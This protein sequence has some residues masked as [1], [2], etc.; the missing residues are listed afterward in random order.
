M[1]WII[2]NEE[3][4]GQ[5][6]NGIQNGHGTHTW[7]LK[8]VPGSQYSL[9]NEYVGNFVNGQRQG[10]G[11]YFYA[12]GAMYDGEWQNNNKHGMGKFV[13][14]NGRIYVGEFVNDQ[15]SEYPNF[16]YDRVNT[17]DLSGIRTQSPGGAGTLNTFPTNSGIPSLAGSYI[18]LDIT[19]L[20]NT[21]PENERLEELKQVE[22][23]ILRNLT[24]LKKTYKYYSSLG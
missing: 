10:H 9:R 21:F 23:G 6:E 20:L 4:I 18:E 12:N 24:V 22:Y 8:R 1:R 14:K 5:W 15:I 13:F 11:Q 17:P 16:K 19:S 3:Y 2:S 7:F